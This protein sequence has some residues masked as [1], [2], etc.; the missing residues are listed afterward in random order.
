MKHIPQLVIA[1]EHAQHDPP[2]EIAMEGVIGDTLDKIKDV[3]GKFKDGFGKK[4]S[5]L[6]D[7]VEENHKAAVKNKKIL[8]KIKQALSTAKRDPSKGIDLGPQ[9]RK[10]G[11]KASTAKDVIK[12]MRERTRELNSQ[13]GKIKAL[14]KDTARLD[15]NAN[16]A[17]KASFKNRIQAI[18]DVLAVKEVAV[19]DVEINFT[20]GEVI[21]VVQ[22]MIDQLNSFEEAAKSFSELRSSRQVLGLE[23]GYEERDDGRERQGPK[24]FFES[25]L[26]AVFEVFLF[27]FKIF[28]VLLGLHFVFVVFFMNPVIGLIG[29]GI[30][31][32]ILN[33]SVAL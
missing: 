23:A 1:A 28:V 18:R 25:I 22:V 32:G 29:I 7:A 3:F 16:E 8:I 24:G 4:P 30:M 9:L 15:G 31:I 19:A 6:F 12:E 11:V 17:Q 26:E 2:I 14:A 33:Y 20:R 21:E 13:W 10:M 27:F 5:D